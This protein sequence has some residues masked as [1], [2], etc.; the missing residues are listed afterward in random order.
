MDGESRSLTGRKTALS[1]FL[2]VNRRG[3][4]AHQ[5]QEVCRRSALGRS[6]LDL[7]HLNSLGQDQLAHS[8]YMDG[9]I[10]IIIS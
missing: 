9:S 6:T 7:E 3:E 4:P 8:S 5:S 10:V 1:C 2:Y